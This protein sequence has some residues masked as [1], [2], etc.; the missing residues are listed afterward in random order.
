MKKR[1]K[2]TEN[3]QIKL[4]QELS[5]YRHKCKC[6]HTMFLIDNPYKICTNCG[7]PVFKDKK[8]EFIYK[9]GGIRCLH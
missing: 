2:R 6:G 1:I 8:S 9:I 3:E 7:K 4:D 5:K